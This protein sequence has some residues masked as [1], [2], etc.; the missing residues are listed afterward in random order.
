MAVECSALKMNLNHAY[1]DSEQ[2]PKVNVKNFNSFFKSGF[3]HP[4]SFSLCMFRFNVWRG[5]K[6]ILARE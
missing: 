6:P 4:G 5:I 1:G 3:E 2:E